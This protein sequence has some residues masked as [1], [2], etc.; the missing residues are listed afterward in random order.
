MR[1]KT[2]DNGAGVAARISQGTIPRET[3][4]INVAETPTIIVP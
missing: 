1:S 4:D 2:N 3:K